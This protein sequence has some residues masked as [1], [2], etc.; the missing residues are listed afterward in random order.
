MSNEKELIPLYNVQY[1]I[2]YFHV[3][4][5][6]NLSTTALLYALQETALDHSK[7]VGY[8]VSTLKENNSGL[9]V[10][11]WH[12][13]VNKQPMLWDTMNIQTWCSKK[14][15]M[16]VDRNFIISNLENTETLLKVVSRWAFIDLE[17]RGAKPMPEDLLVHCTDKEYAID[18]GRF[19]SAY[20]KGEE[21]DLIKESTIIVKRSDIDTNDHVNNVKYVEW[22]LNDIPDDIYNNLDIS[23][24]KIVYRKE[25]SIR[26]EVTLSTYQNGNKLVSIISNKD[27]V[28]LVEI[29]YTFS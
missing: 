25:C 10:L 14:N 15:R 21:G 26:D 7:L 24:L 1:P 5:K 9:A 8:D 22:A 16:Q 3:D 13:T 23:E 28:K 12:I 19:F 20:K 27:N 2:S 6:G 18:Q 11:T 4:P 17:K 29:G